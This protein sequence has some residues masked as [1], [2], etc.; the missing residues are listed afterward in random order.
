MSA[1]PHRPGPVPAAAPCRRRQ[2]DW[3]VG[4]RVGQ[5]RWQ[6]KRSPGWRV[7]HECDTLPEAAAWLT[8]QGADISAVP[9]LSTYPWPMLSNCE[10]IVSPNKE[11]DRDE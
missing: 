9:V 5:S 6:V 3:R 2:D 11:V 1:I 7:A 4:R 10:E 8:A